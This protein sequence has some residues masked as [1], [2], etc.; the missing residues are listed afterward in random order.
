MHL[1]TKLLRFQFQSVP[2]GRAQGGGDGVSTAHHAK[3]HQDM[4][5]AS[6]S[7]N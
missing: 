7:Y 1:G 5:E 2:G 3:R 6:L 4:G